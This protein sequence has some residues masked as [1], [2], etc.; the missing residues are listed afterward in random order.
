M[1]DLDWNKIKYFKKTEKWGD[2]LAMDFSFIK[3]LDQFRGEIQNA[4]SIHC[5]YEKSGH[6]GNSQHYLIPCSAADF[7]LID[8]KVSPLQVYF[9]AEK[10]G[11]NGIGLYPNNG[12]WFVHLDNR[13]LEIGQ[14]KARWIRNNSGDYVSFSDKEFFKNFADIQKKYDIITV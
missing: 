5:G 1:K 11:F 6:V 2:P 3:K 4:I 13:K 14:K 7:H 8:Y 9:T 12:N 10:L